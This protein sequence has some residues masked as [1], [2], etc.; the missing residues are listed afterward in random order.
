MNAHKKQPRL[1]LLSILNLLLPLPFSPPFNE[2]LKRGRAGG[3]DALDGA[4]RVP[5]ALGPMDGD[6]C[7]GEE[8]VFKVGK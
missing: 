1:S 6:G 8:K 7:E 2:H 3:G 5:L 4:E